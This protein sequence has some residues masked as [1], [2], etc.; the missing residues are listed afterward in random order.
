MG[1][2]RDCKK[3]TGRISCS[4][5]CIKLTQ[6]VHHLWISL[7]FYHFLQSTRTTC[8]LVRI[9]VQIASTCFDELYP[10]NVQ[11]V[12]KNQRLESAVCTCLTW[13]GLRD[14]YLPRIARRNK[15]SAQGYSG[16]DCRH[17][18]ALFVHPTILSSFTGY[19]WGIRLS[20]S[21]KFSFHHTLSWSESCLSAEEEAAISKSTPSFQ[22]PGCNCSCLVHLVHYASCQIQ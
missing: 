20:K 4:R 19:E 13:K 7:A 15:N 21:K 8:H 6:I 3:S 18:G 14:I 17:C 16:H 12:K 9:A 5:G 1:S 10:E 11:W 2:H 22:T